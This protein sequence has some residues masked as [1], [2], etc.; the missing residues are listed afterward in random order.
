MILSAGLVI[1]SFDRKRSNVVL[2]G[3]TVGKEKGASFGR[4]SVF[5]TDEKFQISV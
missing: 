3:L 5:R 2:C 4:S 1:S